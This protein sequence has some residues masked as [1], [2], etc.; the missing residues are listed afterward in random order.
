[1]SA[2][3]Q[4]SYSKTFIRSCI[5]YEVLQKK[6]VFEAYET[7]CNT[8]KE[9]IAYKEFDYWFHR[10]YN[11]N[12]DLEDD[13]WQI[14]VRNSNDLRCSINP[15]SEVPH[16][17]SEIDWCKKFVEYFNGVPQKPSLIY[18]MPEKVWNEICAKMELYDRL[19][20]RKVSRNFRDK[21]DQQELH[22]NTLGICFEQDEA[23]LFLNEKTVN[24][25][26]VPNG[27]TII[28]E[29]RTI[30][31]KGGDYRK[32]ALQDFKTIVSKDAKTFSVL[33]DAQMSEQIRGNIF[34]DVLDVLRSMNKLRVRKLVCELKNEEIDAILPYF[35]P[36]TLEVVHFFASSTDGHSTKLMDTVQLKNAKALIFDIDNCS[37]NIEKFFHLTYFDVTLDLFTKD[38]AVKIRDILMK[39]DT[40]KYANFESDDFDP[41]EIANVFVPDYQ[42]DDW[43]II[44]YTRHNKKFLLKINPNSFQIKKMV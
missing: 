36:K 44:N 13:T 5:L 30:R 26:P 3:A 7:I 4:N 34:K 29:N 38:D 1:M 25:C 28:Y 2:T 9:K 27:C 10:F 6:P 17:I 8:L 20:A 24:Y 22:F 37:I 35:E 31:I 41:I 12:H 19:V 18:N 39:S 33:F 42:S 16:K 11:G 43:P 23:R 32:I 40:F 14:K 21:I 15:P